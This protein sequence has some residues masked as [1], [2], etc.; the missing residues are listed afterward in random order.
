MNFVFKNED[1]FFSWEEYNSGLIKFNF[2]GVNE[3]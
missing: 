3:I 2:H 1:F